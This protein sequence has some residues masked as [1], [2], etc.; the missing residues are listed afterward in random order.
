L[1]PESRW[2]NPEAASNSL[3]HIANP[4]APLAH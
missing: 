2:Y 1:K 4:L 3:N